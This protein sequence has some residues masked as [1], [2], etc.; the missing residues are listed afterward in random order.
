[1]PLTQ[2]HVHF[3]GRA[4]ARVGRR[5]ASALGGEGASQAGGKIKVEWAGTAPSPSSTRSLCSIEAPRKCL[6]YR[7]KAE[8]Y[9]EGALVLGKKLDWEWGDRHA[10]AEGRVKVRGLGTSSARGGS[11]CS[12]RSSPA[13]AR[14]FRSSGTGPEALRAGDGA[15]SRSI[16]AGRAP[17]R[18]SPETQ[19]S[20]RDDKRPLVTGPVYG[21]DGRP[22]ADLRLLFASGRT[23]AWPLGGS[24]RSRNGLGCVRGRH[25]RSTDGNPQAPLWTKKRWLFHR[26][27]QRRKPH[28]VRDTGLLTRSTAAS[29]RDGRGCARCP[30]PPDARSRV[31]R[32]ERGHRTAPLDLEPLERRPDPLLA[33]RVQDRLCFEPHHQRL[34]PKQPH[35]DIELCRVGH[36]HLLGPPRPG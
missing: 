17:G 19:G 23:A 26:D 31:R 27:S 14:S 30:G 3:Y 4:Y 16:R 35:V 1:M 20:A 5:G 2:A 22:R 15:R 28:D 9:A 21:L 8:T 10:T 11:D 25:G 18:A 36:Q 34:H 13:V 7:R 32:P 12:S 24:L 29:R 6:W 33:L